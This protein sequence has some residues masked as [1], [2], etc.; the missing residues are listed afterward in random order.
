[1]YLAEQIFVMKFNLKH[2]ILL[3]TVAFFLSGCGNNPPE[4]EEEVDVNNY[5]DQLL[6]DEAL[7]Q[8]YLRTHTY[9][10]EDFPPQAGETAQILIDTLAGDFAN[11][12]PLIDLVESIEV[13]V[14]SDGESINHRM[15]R[16][17]ANQGERTG[18]KPSIAD[19]V[20]L[21]YKGR[22]LDGSVFD[23]NQYPVWFDLAAVI[24]GFRYGLQE[25]A[26]G[27][28][29]VE[30][31]GSIRFEDFGQG[32]IFFPSALGYYS[33]IKSTIPAYSPLIFEVSVYTVNTADHDFDGILSI[34]EDPDGDGNPYNDDTDGDGLTNM[35]DADDDGDG[36]LTINEYDTDEDG[37]IDDDDNDGTPNY[38]DPD[39]A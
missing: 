5:S 14:E 32:A 7:L 33:Q 20:Y 23:Q 6:V 36:V 13:P 24:S 21:A 30:N 11:K 39:A 12:I 29:T 3:L 8:A 18:F 2:F 37:V 26:P 19:S 27:N 35:F 28:Y 22:L 4:I 17:L 15:Y 16:L 38:L 9:N 1:M 10:Y 34:Y 25:F 31:D